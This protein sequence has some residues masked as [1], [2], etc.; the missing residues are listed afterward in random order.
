MLVLIVITLGIFIPKV[1]TTYTTCVLPPACRISHLV[2]NRKIDKILCNRLDVSFECSEKAGGP[3]MSSMCYMYFN[4]PWAKTLDSSFNLKQLEKMLYL[5]ACSMSRIQFNNINGF[6]INSYE[7][8]ESIKLNDTVSPIL[9]YL[10]T[11]MNFFSRNKLISSCDDYIENNIGLNL[12][13]AII[14]IGIWFRHVKFDKPICPLIFNNSHL[15]FVNFDYVINTYYKRN[16]LRFVTNFNGVVNSTIEQ[17]IFMELEKV[18]VDSN[19]INPK[20][21]TKLTVVGLHGEVNSVE[22]GLFNQMEKLVQIQF[23]TSYFK[24][25]AHKKGIGWIKLLN[26]DVDIFSPNQ[27]FIGIKYT[28]I[29]LKILNQYYYWSFNLI[30]P[31]DKLFPN[32]DFCLYLEFPLHRMVVLTV[33]TEK[34]VF[35]V[36]HL[37]C[38]F[39]W[40][41]RYISETSLI[42]NAA[43]FQVNQFWT[44]F[45]KLN[46]IENLSKIL[47]ECEFDKRVKNC[48]ISNTTL[49]PS[50]PS[51][52][53]FSEQMAL[54]Q[55]SSIIT[56][57]LIC[58][59]GLVTNL[60]VVYV[61]AKDT[62]KV[63][64]EKQ[65]TYMMLR[66]IVN[67]IILLIQ[68]FSVL[69]Q[70]Q[71]ENGLFCSSIHR[72]LFVQY[73]KIVFVEF[74][75]NYFRLV[76]NLFYI[77]FLF[78]RLSLV[79]KDHN[80]LTRFLSDL[81]VLYFVIFSFIVGFVISFVK[82]FRFQANVSYYTFDYPSLYTSAYDTNSNIKIMIAFS[83]FNMICD[84]IN[85][86]V[87][88]IA[89]IIID[90]ILVRKLRET[91]DSK[92]NNREKLTT[93]TTGNED[94][95]LRIVV[96]VILNSIINLVL[97]LPSTLLSIIETIHSIGEFKEN[98]IEK[99]DLYK[100]LM[101]CYYTGL[102]QAIDQFIVNMFLLSLGL[103]FL[104]YY[105]FDKNFKLST[106]NTFKKTGNNRNQL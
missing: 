5:L 11:K 2:T 79:G 76:A 78:N 55:F 42:F 40:L 14:P 7:K 98:S 36:N 62:N 92:M 41:I 61:V 37:S 23:I 4:L 21:C 46:S 30:N 96:L 24:L 70:C 90:I 29:D 22:E 1:S 6:E 57:P 33:E 50:E 99:T 56:S 39:L 81:K 19:L 28:L 63:L 13:Q 82:V 8:N 97:R 54:W 75:G 84:V 83:I 52:K 73:F 101:I 60:I 65:Y 38:T 58:L 47:E 3:D 64:K 91:I 20:L 93:T 95:V 10:N 77:A 26:P 88:L 16:L 48:M 12:F 34:D 32:E 104:L 87:Y 69:N 105:N 45:I 31:I 18:D 66:S 85:G 25:L 35:D 72:L 17:I 27:S 103:D 74:F 68:S 67:S 80:K 9:Y 59:I 89:T 100:S 106:I 102:C 53:D 71:F 44:F 43:N 86:P 49:L 94:P 51:L 15:W